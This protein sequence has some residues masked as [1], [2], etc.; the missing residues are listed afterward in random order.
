MVCIVHKVLIKKEEL[1]RVDTPYYFTYSMSSSLL[2]GDSI[3]DGPAAS[4][5]GPLMYG[6]CTPVKIVI[7]SILFSKVG[8]TLEHYEWSVDFSNLR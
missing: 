5:T 7:T 2:V 1:E 8:S 6:L 3:L 4:E